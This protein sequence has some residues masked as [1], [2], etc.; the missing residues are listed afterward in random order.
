[1]EWLPEKERTTFYCQMDKKQKKAYDDMLK[2]FMVENTD[3]DASGVLAQLTRLRQICLDPSL[4]GIDAPSAKTE[5]LVEWITES[6]PKGEGVVIM[7]MFTSYFHSLKKILESK[8]FRVGMI[9]G[10][11]T[12]GQKIESANKFQNG[13]VDIL[14]C[15]IISAGTGFTLDRADTI[16]FM[17]KAWNPAENEQAEDRITPTTMDNVHKHSIISFVC[18]NSV[19]QKINELLEHKKSLTDIINEGGL[20][21]IRKL[22]L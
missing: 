15:N 1:M 4:L 21:A 17:D 13:Q 11:M 5:S 19:D 16:I 14:L 7:S 3:V 12:S 8:K 6:L 10:S 9:H 22:L 18:Q 20:K 2:Y